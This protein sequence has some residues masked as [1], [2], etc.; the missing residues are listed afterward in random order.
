MEEEKVYPHDYINEDDDE[1]K[2]KYWNDSE[3]DAEEFFAD[4]DSEEL[5]SVLYEHVTILAV[6]VGDR[7]VLAMFITVIHTKG[8]DRKPQPQ[9]FHF[10]LLFI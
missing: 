3:D 2:S 10:T 9:V 6:R 1:Y 4:A 8:E 5:K 7:S